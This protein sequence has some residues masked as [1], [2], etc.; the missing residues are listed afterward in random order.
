MKKLPDTL[1]ASLAL[2]AL[3]ASALAPTS[4]FA[5][6]IAWTGA[7][8]DGGNVL[9]GTNWDGDAAPGASDRAQIGDAP[10]A[11]LSG[12]WAPQYLD[13]GTTAGKTGTLTVGSGGE[14]SVTTVNNG[15][16]VTAGSVRMGAA[17]GAAAV[18]NIDGGTMT[19]HSLNTPNYA[20]TSTVNMASGT[21]N[22]TG[23]MDWGRNANG[24]STF[25]QSGGTVNMGGNLW[26]GRDNNGT[27]IY[28]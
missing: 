3:V 15:T 7:A 20:A 16:G 6:D 4:L 25:N 24:L 21:L 26:I 14:L 5:T 8:D 23:W 2:L 10:E 11:V 9:T 17:A 27:A 18:L 13:I 22:I 1:C 19:V 28:N 12:S